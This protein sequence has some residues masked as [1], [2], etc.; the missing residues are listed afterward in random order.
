[1]RTS[2]PRPGPLYLCHVIQY[3]LDFLDLLVFLVFL[4]FL[5]HLDFQDFPKKKKGEFSEKSGLYL[6]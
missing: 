5:E 1:M 3:V 6:K 2:V 4:L